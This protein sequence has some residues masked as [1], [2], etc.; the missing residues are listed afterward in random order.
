LLSLFQ[1]WIFPLIS[2]LIIPFCAVWL[3]FR[4]TKSQAE[5]ELDRNQKV[6]R[7][8]LLLLLK[9]ECEMFLEYSQ[10]NNNYRSRRFISSKQIMDSPYFNVNEHSKLIELVLELE[11]VHEN[12]GIAVEASMGIIANTT[13]GYT[14][15]PLWMV[16]AHSFEKLIGN[17]TS[18]DKTIES[19]NKLVKGIIDD[20]T[21]EA[22]PIIKGLITEIDCLLE[23][24]N[25]VS[26]GTLGQREAAATYESS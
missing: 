17:K 11:R 7:E 10:K 1:Q 13:G 3:G 8:K 12:I 23:N 9:K 20:S 21:K 19:L 15:P 18:I 4:I 26:P 14:K 5:K 25:F 22:D 2:G 24:D 16:F 6:Q